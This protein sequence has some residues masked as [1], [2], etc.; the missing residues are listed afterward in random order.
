MNILLDAYFDRNFGDDLFVET[1]TGLF[2]ECRFYAYLE[3]FPEK[4]CEWAAGLPNLYQLPDCGVFLEKEMFD[5]YICVGGDIFPNGGDFCKRKTYAE[6]LR[7]YG[8]VVAFLGFN[9][10]Q[11]YTEASRKDICEI[12]KTA[13]II[14]PRD[15]E[16]AELLRQWIPGIQVKTMPDL[17]F[18]SDW[19]NCRNRCNKLLG[20]SVRKLSADKGNEAEYCEGMSDV[21]SRYLQK[22]T[23]RKVVLLCL[24]DGSFADRETAEEIMALL[25]DASRVE[26]V[27]YQGDILSY[28]QAIGRCESVICTRFHALIA[29]I[30]ME[31]PFLPVVYEV[32]QEHILRSIGYR[33]EKFHYHNIAGLY[34]ALEYMHKDGE[35]ELLWEKERI[36]RYPQQVSDVISEFSQLLK[37]LE[38][39]Q[40][41]CG[42]RK[43]EPACC[44]KQYGRLQAQQVAH[45]NEELCKLAEEVAEDQK[46]IKQCQET[47]AQYIQTIEECNQTNRNYF[48]LIEKLNQK[49]C[50]LEEERSHLSGELQNRHSVWQLQE[51]EYLGQ[52]EEQEGCIGEQKKQLEEQAVRM[53]EQEL[54]REKLQTLKR[55]QEE[56]LHMIAPYFTSR[57]FGKFTRAMSLVM[58][59]RTG[60]LPDRKRKL[61]DWNKIRDYLIRAEK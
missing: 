5:A 43:T 50:R 53:R 38:G 35:E 13:D 41:I 6:T 58:K 49:I 26:I 46:I 33:G 29:C 12:M 18:Y 24:S 9:L 40:I 55:S 7:R 48:C 15:E 61:Q 47:I 10:F 20:V 19:Q 59:D 51:K 52:I 11:E 39:K 14:A 8:G 16:S 32:K 45:K 30:A 21:I 17:A 4:V 3:F 31:I 34:H 28:K 27:P 44:E 42:Q 1:I 36:G 2:P 56:I 37:A 60:M 54:Q 25:P 22:D 57:V 23:E